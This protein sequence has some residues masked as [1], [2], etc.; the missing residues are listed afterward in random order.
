[1]S[2][3]K[4]PLFAA[5]VIRGPGR[6]PGG[7]AC[8]LTGGSV[9]AAPARWSLIAAV[10]SIANPHVYGH[11]EVAT[12]GEPGSYTWT[13]TNV[14][15][16]AGIARY[17]GASGLDGP[18]SKAAGAASASGT[19]PSVT[20][21]TADAMLVGCM[22]IDSGSATLTSPSGL[23]QAWE[24]TVRSSELADGVQDQAGASGAKTWTFASPDW[25]GLLVALRPR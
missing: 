1:M 9:S 20:T 12:A 14:T 22:G 15:G 7:R 16:S 18:A 25:A 3:R 6:C 10:N 11:H 23:S 2:R 13:T 21:T 8:R 19:V 5:L 24:L 17:S 4:R